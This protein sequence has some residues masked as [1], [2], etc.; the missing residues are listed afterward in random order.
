M[1]TNGT[2]SDASTLLSTTVSDSTATGTHTVIVNQVAQTE[3]DISATLSV[4]TTADVTGLLGSGFSSG[5]FRIYESGKASNVDITVSAGDSLS[6]IA[7]AINNISDQ[8]GVTASVISVS[9]TQSV[10]VLSGGD[11]NAALSFEDTDG[12]LANLGVVK[13]ATQSDAVS[14]T[15]A[16]GV[17]GTFQLYNA[18][19]TGVDITVSATATLDDIKTAINAQTTTTGVTASI[20]TVDSTTSRLVLTSSDGSTITY[21]DASG[22]VLSDLGLGQTSAADQVQVAQGAILTVDGVSGITRNTNTITDIVSGVTL[23]LKGADA[24]TKVTPDHQAGH[25]VDRQR[26][27]G[28]RHRLQQLADLRGRQRCHQQRR[29]RRL[30]R[31]A[32]WRRHT[33][34]GK[35]PTGIRD[36]RDAVGNI[37]CLQFGQPRRHRHFA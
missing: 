20:T 1:A 23:N 16:L 24:N 10:L 6:D 31:G 15:D 27:R 17:S 22:S 28:F 12:I 2:P 14:S 7:T 32:V 9:S 26:H 19:G 5:T 21:D 8:T 29:H 11:E 3:V 30:D 34:L 33:A 18:S 25:L 36:R 13:A 4:A 37:R 35:L